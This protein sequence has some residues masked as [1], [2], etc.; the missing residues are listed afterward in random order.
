MYAGRIVEQGPVRAD[1]PTRRSIPTRAACWPRSR[2]DARRAAARDRGHRADARR[3]CRPAARSSRAVRDRFEPLRRR[4]RRR[5]TTSDRT[6]A[7]RC[8]LLRSAAPI[9]SI[10]RQSRATDAARRCPRISSK[11][12]PAAGGLFRTRPRSSRAVDDVSF[13]IDEGETFGLVGESGSGK[14]TT[15]RCILRLIE[16]TSGEVLFRGENVLAFSRDEHAR[17][18]PR[19][20]RSCFRI[21]TRR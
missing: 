13:T 19:T 16:P 9:A 15:G 3:R 21:R 14:T 1:L 17:G 6:S 20:C 5:R 4:R 8:Y 7:A 2:A 10:A 12:S 11:H 18:A